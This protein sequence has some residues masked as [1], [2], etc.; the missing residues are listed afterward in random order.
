M[1]DED[2]IGLHRLLPPF[3]AKRM[4]WRQYP[5]LKKRK[6][7]PPPLLPLLP[8][9]ENYLPMLALQQTAHFPNGFMTL[10]CKKFHAEGKGLASIITFVN[11][12]SLVH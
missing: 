3:R 7:I 2:I 4:D 1:R 8:E 10:I 5:I 6:A 9:F 12:F 11:L